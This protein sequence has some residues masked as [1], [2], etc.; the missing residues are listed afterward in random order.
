MTSIPDALDELSTG[1]RTRM[2]RKQPRR[3]APLPA[4]EIRAAAEAPPGQP[5]PTLA[6]L[7]AQFKCSTSSVSRILRGDSWPG[8][9]GPIGAPRPRGKAVLGRRVQV[10][11]PLELEAAVDRARGRQSARDWLVQAAAERIA[12]SKEAK[13]AGESGL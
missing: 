1:R 5:R 11:L 7:A 4:A 13:P 10:R 6:A 3:G 2:P 9:G 12:R 8:V